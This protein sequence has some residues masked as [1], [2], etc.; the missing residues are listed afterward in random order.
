MWGGTR[1]QLDGK[2]TSASLVR[3]VGAAQ[4]RVAVA[5]RANGRFPSSWLTEKSKKNMTWNSCPSHEKS[6]ATRALA[7]FPHLNEIRVYITQALL[8][9]AFEVWIPAT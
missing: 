9:A 7:W 8:G 2:L 5:K 3:R 4:S 6:T 1:G